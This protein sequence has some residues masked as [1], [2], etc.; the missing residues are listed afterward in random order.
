M[1]RRALCPALGWAEIFGRDEMPETLAKLGEGFLLEGDHFIC[2]F[3]LGGARFPA[4]G[5][6]MKSRE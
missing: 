5:L 3:L 2:K 6:Q 1:A 4:Q